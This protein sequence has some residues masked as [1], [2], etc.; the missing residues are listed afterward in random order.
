MTSHE[1][2]LILLRG[3]S[4]LFVTIVLCDEVENSRLFLGYWHVVNFVQKDVDEMSTLGIITSNWPCMKL[5]SSRMV[6]IIRHVSFIYMREWLGERG[7][8]KQYL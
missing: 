4:L 5:H 1:I 7:S 2:A 6:K 3:V 8:S